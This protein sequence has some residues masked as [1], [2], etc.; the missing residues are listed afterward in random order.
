MYAITVDDA[1][2]TGMS[3]TYELHVVVEPPPAVCLD[4]AISIAT[5]PDQIVIVGACTSIIKID[6]T[7]PGDTITGNSVCGVYGHD[8][9]DAEMFTNIVRNG[10]DYGVEIAGTI[11]DGEIDVYTFSVEFWF[12]D[13]FDGS[14]LTKVA[15]NEFNVEI[16]SCT[17]DN[18]QL[19]NVQY[20][21]D[22]NYILGDPQGIISW[23][24]ADIAT[25]NFPLN[26]DVYD[27]T[28]TRGFN[29][30]RQNLIN[31][32]SGIFTINQSSRELAFQTSDYT[33]AGKHNIHFYIRMRCPS[34]ERFGPA[35][36]WPFNVFVIDPTCT[37][38]NGL[39]VAMNVLSDPPTYL[40]TGIPI[41][42]SMSTVF[43]SSNPSRCP[44][45]YEC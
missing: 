13:Y 39:A 25:S 32:V 28:F 11:T 4:T 2:Y 9:I 36:S 3:A 40:Y 1:V 34:G 18:V 8:L 16:K 15:S 23:T 24:Y 29:G 17:K 10:A 12:K 38:A 27:I 42:N 19:S 44:I 6:V 14:S 43:T 20:F 31:F 41:T 45:K 5:I 26:C 35:N 22:T 33:K 37:S 7:H 21:R 30:S